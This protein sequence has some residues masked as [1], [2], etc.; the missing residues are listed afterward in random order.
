MAVQE[1][2]QNGAVAQVI[3]EPVV[4]R[5]GAVES[6][7]FVLLCLYVVS[8][9]ANE[10]AIRW[11]GAKAYLSAIVLV[12]LPIAL[13]LSRNRFRGLH[14]KM[15][16]WWLF[17]LLFLLLDAPFSVWRTGTL[18]L[19]TSYVPRSYLNFLFITAFV[20]TLDR[21]RKFMYVNI[22]AS[23]I[24]LVSCVSFGR[25]SSDGRLSVPDSL[26]L[27]NANELGLQLLLG[28][29]Q[30]VY[31]LYQRGALKKVV[32]VGLIV[33]SVMYILRAGSRSCM[34]GAI[35]YCILMIVFS[36]NKVLVIALVLVSGLVAV[37]TTPS[38]ALRR[39][40]LLFEDSTAPAEA[41]AVA[42]EMSRKE[43]FRRSLVTTL[44]HPLFGVG[45]G[46]FAVYVAKEKTKTGEWAEWLGTHNSY[47]QIS[48]ECGIPCL[49]CY[50]A[51]IAICFR[52]NFRMFKITRGDPG[53]REV[54]GL[55]FTL[56]SMIL[57]YAVCTNFFHMA[58]TSTLPN[59][60]GTTLALYWA[61]KQKIQKE[62]DPKFA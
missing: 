46:Q 32:A 5:N 31:L 13:I 33:V 29:T 48:A 25:Y 61:T 43:L 1:P 53:F 3:P 14:S 59:I 52:L 24:A 56:L 40:M 55:S 7:G 39:L 44:Q 47:T 2:A 20:T 19:I 36:R 9:F 37:A 27:A 23:A 21:C 30:F 60:A 57:A 62:L 17:F 8:G 15:G 35:C 34:V 11:F 38:M 6:L 50:V 58:Y 41:S 54:A 45:P 51:V 12:G 26:F 49:I 10:F 4:T 22:F 16:R 28:A 18:D 42:S